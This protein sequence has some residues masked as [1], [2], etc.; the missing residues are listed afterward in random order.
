MWLVARVVMLMMGL[1]LV[2]VGLVGQWRWWGY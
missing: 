2:P 1:V